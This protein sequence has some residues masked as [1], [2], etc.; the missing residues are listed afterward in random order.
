MSVQLQFMA[1]SPGVTG[2]FQLKTPFTTLPRERCECIALRKLSEYIAE[3]QDPWAEI[4]EPAGL[5]K[6][7]YETD[8]ARNLEIAVLVTTRGYRIQVPVSYVEGYPIQDGVP[9]HGVGIFMKLPPM[10]VQQNLDFLVNSMKE[11]IK[12]QA[13]VDATHEMVETTAVQMVDVN[14]HL[15]EQASRKVVIGSDTTF[16]SQVSRLQNDLLDAQGKIRQ[17]EDYII[18]NLTP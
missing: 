1:P 16:A 7:E 4:Y 8:L 2:V 9:Y 10:P 15:T 11:V 18:Q 17:L 14:K 3:N 6:S 13:G 5:Q 12:S